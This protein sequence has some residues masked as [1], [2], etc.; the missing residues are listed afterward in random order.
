MVELERGLAVWNGKT[1]SVLD[2]NKEDRSL[3][4]FCSSVVISYHIMYKYVV[5]KI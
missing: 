1:S 4:Q 5:G 3:T 2:N